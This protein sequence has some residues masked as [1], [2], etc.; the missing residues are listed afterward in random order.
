MS[1]HQTLGFLL[2]LVAVIKEQISYSLRH[3]GPA[4]PAGRTI[5]EGIG[6]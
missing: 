1:D 5:R 2:Q 3:T 6:S 4:W